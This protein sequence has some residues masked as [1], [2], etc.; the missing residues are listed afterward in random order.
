MNIKEMNNIQSVSVFIL[1]T[2]TILIVHY[3]FKKYYNFIFQSYLGRSI[4]IALLILCS[5]THILLGGFTALLLMF[6]YKNLY[7]YKPFKTPDESGLLLTESQ[8][9]HE[10]SLIKSK[11]PEPTEFIDTDKYSPVFPDVEISKGYS[12][13]ALEGRNTFELERTIYG[14]NSNQFD[15]DP[16]M[17]VPEGPVKG[18]S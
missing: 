10:A 11:H 17:F 13:D 7:I 8:M 1:F 5:Y 6:T 15:V 2:I 4:L 14:K 12:I 9:Q 3:G 18:V 16:D